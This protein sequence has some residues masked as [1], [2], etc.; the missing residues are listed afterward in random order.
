MKTRLTPYYIDLVYDACYRSFW[1][2]KTLANFLNQCGVSESFLA[3][4]MPE[5][6]KRDLLDRLFPKLLKSGEGKQ[7]FLKLAKYLMEQKS[8]PDLKN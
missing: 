5:E 2:R 3:S 8:F 7:V 1:R 6:S 4:W